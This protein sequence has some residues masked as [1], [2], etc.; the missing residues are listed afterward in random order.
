M[1]KAEAIMRTVAATK[2]DKAQTE[3]VVTALLA[4]IMHAVECGAAVFVPGFGTFH[5]LWRNETTGRLIQKNTAI[6][7]PAHCI[8]HFK[9]Y[10]QFKNSIKT[11]R[12]TSVPA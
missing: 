8:P 5:T 11:R 4:G 10:R 1:T 12:P 9:P 6:I 3:I 7:I 2:Q